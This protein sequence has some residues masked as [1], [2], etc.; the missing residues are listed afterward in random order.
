VTINE[1][2][3]QPDSLGIIITLHVDSIWMRP[4]GPII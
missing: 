3:G 4:S 1:L 2:P